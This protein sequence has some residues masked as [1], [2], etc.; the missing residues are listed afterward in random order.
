MNNWENCGWSAGVTQ[1]LEYAL[2]MVLGTLLPS[3]GAELYG[4]FNVF[5]VLNHSKTN[6]LSLS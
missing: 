2:S 1:Y 4:E 5:V 6:F 3:G